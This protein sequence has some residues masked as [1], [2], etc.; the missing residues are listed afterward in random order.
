MWVRKGWACKLLLPGV[1]VSLALRNSRGEMPEWTRGYIVLRLGNNSIENN[2]IEIVGL[3]EGRVLLLNYF[4]RR[5]ALKNV[6]GPARTSAGTS[7]SAIGADTTVFQSI[8]ESA[9]NSNAW[10]RCRGS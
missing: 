2:S 1:L 9:R 4:W 3:I 6:P 7:S 8:W 5:V 10:V